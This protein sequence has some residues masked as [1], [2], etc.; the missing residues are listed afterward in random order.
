MR[1]KIMVVDDETDIRLTVGQIL[2]ASGYDVV[3]AES[4]MVC[5]WKLERE[6]PDL[7]ILDIM[8]P[9]MSGWD[10]AAHIKQHEELSSI[11]IVF[12]TAKGDDFSV[13]MGRMASEEYI[14]KPFDV[15]ELKASVDRILK[16]Y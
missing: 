15:M 11:P 7:I 3:S 1:K 4:G 13:G 16:K 10:V 5:L 2:K 9:G 12:L 14:V 8:M 6:R